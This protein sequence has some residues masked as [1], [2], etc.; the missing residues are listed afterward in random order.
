M[1]KSSDSLQETPGDASCA[2]R[3]RATGIPV[4]VG[5][6]IALAV[7]ALDQISKLLAGHF[8]SDGHGAVLIPGV[9]EFRYALNPGAAWG[10]LSGC[11]WLLLL[12]GI[13][14]IVLTLRYLNVIV[15]GSRVRG[16]AVF[17]VLGGIVGNSIDRIWQGQV[18]DFIS[19]DLQFYKWPI[20]NIADSAICIGVCLYLISTLFGGRGNGEKS[21][22]NAPES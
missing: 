22:K 13:A 10:M 19:V 20:F 5:T 1:M 3:R 14:A 8:L 17:L 12:I 2:V 9:L 4:P 18:V 6:G 21:E 16:V 11:S 7:L 15:E